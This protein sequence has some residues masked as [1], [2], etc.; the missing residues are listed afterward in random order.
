M[1]SFIIIANYY[2][3]TDEHWTPLWIWLTGKSWNSFL[4]MLLVAL[5]TSIQ[6][7]IVPFRWEFL[8]N[9]PHN[10]LS[11][12]LVFIDVCNHHTSQNNPRPYSMS[13]SW[14]WIA[15]QFTVLSTMHSLAKY[16][17]CEW[18]SHNRNPS[19]FKSYQQNMMINSINQ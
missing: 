8:R 17:P 6:N 5:S 16:Y 4:K 13:K 9:P 19:I 11:H 15:N 18:P 1:D 7:D 10:H 12:N 3:E 14:W 2:D